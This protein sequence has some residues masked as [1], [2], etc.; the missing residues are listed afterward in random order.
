MK[1][2]LILIVDDE[3]IMVNILGELLY[4]EYRIIFAKNGPKALQ[5]CAE[6]KELPDL[7]LL[8]VMMPELDGFETCRRIKADERLVDIPV[9]FMTALDTVED[10]VT[11]FKAGGVDYITKPFQQTEVLIRINTHINMRKKAQK[12]KETQEELLLQKN[13]L[14]AL[15]NSIPDP[16]YI[17]DV[18]NK[19]IGCNRAFEEIAGKPE[20]DIVGKGDHAVL[21]REVA[22][23][24]RT[25]DQEML[26]SREAGRTEELIIAPNG[27]PLFFDIRKTPYI[28]PD[29]N[30]LRLFQHI[31]IT[32]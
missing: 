1:K 29:G 17:K 16:I 8:D 15:I 5:R 19:Y 18:E 7:I 31:N 23:A 20:E 6:G 12:L 3:T 28:G 22:A 10:K 24:F 32:A 13:K 30:L 27:E 11:G 21:S 25:N 14:E 9:I 4:E 2:P 26:I